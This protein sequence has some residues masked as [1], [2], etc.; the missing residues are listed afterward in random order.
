[1][2]NIFYKYL[3]EN[4]TEHVVHDYIVFIN[5]SLQSEFETTLRVTSGQKWRYHLPS[6]RPGRNDYKVGTDR[7]ERDDTLENIRSF[8][9]SLI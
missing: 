1:M 3:R 9:T 8:T 7:P 5:L 4:I 6:G 2:N